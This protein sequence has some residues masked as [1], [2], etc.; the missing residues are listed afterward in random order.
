MVKYATTGQTS[1]IHICSRISI[2]SGRILIAFHWLLTCVTMMADFLRWL[3]DVFRFFCSIHTRTLPQE[4][5]TMIS[6]IDK[7]ARVRDKMSIGNRKWIRPVTFVVSWRKSYSI[8]Q[9]RS[10]LLQSLFAYL[11]AYIH[12]FT[13]IY[14]HT[15]THTHTHI[16]IYINTYIHSHIYARIHI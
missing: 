8:R 5:L 3:V 2:N 11:H 12:T 15:H 1:T 4:P 13:H 16:H 7:R 14:T 10:S 9:F 6:A